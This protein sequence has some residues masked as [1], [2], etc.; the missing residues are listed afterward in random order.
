MQ[1]PDMFNICSTY[2][3][4][5]AYNSFPVPTEIDM[6]ALYEH[7]CDLFEDVTYNEAENALTVITSSIEWLKDYDY[8]TYQRADNNIASNVRLTEKGLRALRSFPR[9][10][11]PERE[12]I[13]DILVAAG[14]D[15]TK[16]AVLKGVGALF[17]GIIEL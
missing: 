13:G 7:I 4:G 8:L 12:T 11:D 2:I 6:F 14:K 17:S 15:G 5:N 10:I 1:N 16:E 9:S 3:L